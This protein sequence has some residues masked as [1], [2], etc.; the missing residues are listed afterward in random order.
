MENYTI[1][2]EKQNQMDKEINK[3]RNLSG[4]LNVQNYTSKPEVEITFIGGHQKQI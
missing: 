4:K 1:N 2:V 3:K